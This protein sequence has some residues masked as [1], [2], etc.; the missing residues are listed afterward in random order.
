M[1]IKVNQVW[2]NDD[3][4][5]PLEKFNVY[6]WLA[7][8]HEVT[9][10]AHRW[11]F[12]PHTAGSLDVEG[13]KIKDLNTILFKDDDKEK[14]KTLPRSRELLKAWLEATK[15]KKPADVCFIYNLI[16]VTKS[17]IGGTRQGIVLDMKAGPSKHLSDYNNAFN[18][19]FVSYSRGG[20]T[21]GKPENQCMGTM[22]ASDTLRGKY[23][24]KFES[25]VAAGLED[26]KKDPNGKWFNLV[27]RWH[28]ESFLAASPNID[29]ALQAPN[30]SNVKKDEYV[31]DEIGAPNH[32]PFRVFKMAS[33]QTNKG[34]LKTPPE[35]I[36]N[37]AQ[38]VWDDELKGAVGANK[39]YLAK[40]EAAMKDLPGWTAPKPKTEEKP[41]CPKCKKQFKAIELKMHSLSCK[42][43]VCD[44][45]KLT[46]EGDQIANHK[47]KGKK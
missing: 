33:D 45:C 6:S 10:Y 41:T 28:G 19:M 3:P 47:C 14:A 26:Y 27:T 15:K 22:E 40:A 44:A 5:G 23:A 17:Y 29:V 9:I 12:T 38:R 43:A 34:G 11:N 32:G 42:G 36:A 18:K 21:V 8:G 39:G 37:L 2:Y 46:F 30:G 4:L 1:A 13:V 24:A 20:N 25:I 31:V 16:D 35:K 7:L